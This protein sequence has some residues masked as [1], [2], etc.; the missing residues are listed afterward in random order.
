MRQVA[1]AAG[2]EVA[3]VTVRNGKDRI[4]EKLASYNRAARYGAWVVLRDSDQDCPVELRR[5]LLDPLGELSPR[6]MLR[7][8]KSMSEAWILADRDAFAS[9]FKVRPSLVPTDP[10]S[11]PH[12][13]RT[14]LEIC[15]QSTS[16]SLREDMVRPGW[17]IGPLYVEWIN[18]FARSD[19][20]V[21]VA[22]SSA[23]SLSRAVE[24]IRS[25]PQ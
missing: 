22:A 16:R 3:K 17:K 21:E 10:E 9:F 5:R 20:R 25:L 11:L 7:L 12:A 24:R 2:H 19:W 6:F 1:S 4:D 13:K 8:A 15:A 23:D 14:L 18:E